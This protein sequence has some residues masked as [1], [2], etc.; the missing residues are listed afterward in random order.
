MPGARRGAKR[1]LE[2]RIAAEE[3]EQEAFL[4]VKEKEKKEAV[5]EKA[6]ASP[7][8]KEKKAKPVVTKEPKFG[9]FAEK[10]K[11]AL[12]KNGKGKKEKK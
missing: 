7:E 4:A 1:V 10:L 9:L 2:E 11:K 5:V 8:V 6:D 12:D 3:Y